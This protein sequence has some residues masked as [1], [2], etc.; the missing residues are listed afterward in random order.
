MNYIYE[1]TETKARYLTDKILWNDE[2]FW[3]YHLTDHS[4]DNDI[5]INQ[6]EFNNEYKFVTIEEEYI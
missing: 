1:N 6:E 5:L 3:L 4:G 2:G